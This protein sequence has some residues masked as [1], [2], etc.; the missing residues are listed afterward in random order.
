MRPDPR[1]LIRDLGLDPASVVR[2]DTLSERHGHGIWRI[3]TAQRT[4][5]LKWMP[6]DAARVEIPGYR[7]LQTLEV[8]TL[9]LYGH[10]PQALLMEDLT[11]SPTWR[12]ATEADAARPEVGRA[13]AHWYR[14]FHQAGETLLAQRDPPGFLARESDAL[15]PASIR[16]TAQTLNLA[17]LPVW[18]LAVDH[19]AQLKAA[20]ETLGVTLNY[21]DFHWTNLA[22]SRETD[23]PTGK[24]HAIVFDYHLLG[25]GMRASDCRN[26]AGGLAG[27]AVSAF[28]SVYGEVDSREEVLDRPLATLYGLHAA[29]RLP[30]FPRW[31]ASS[32]DRAVDGGLARDLHTAVDLAQSL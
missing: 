10:T 9:P 28:W 2:I 16:T 31:A 20:V 26:A 19:V 11:R 5:V 25:I 7:L 29:A 24:R 17:H 12:L 1:A 22:L 21:N 15:T 18:D 4:A 30:H 6:E 8:P 32:R 3:V 27:E 13:V 23:G 14:T